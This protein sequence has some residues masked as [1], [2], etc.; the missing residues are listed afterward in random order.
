MH[1]STLASLRTA[2][3]IGHRGLA[4]AAP[5]NTMAAFVAAQ[6]AGLRWVELDAKL[7][8]SGE[9]I[10]L[11]DNSVDRTS[12]GRGRA[13]AMSYQQLRKLDAGSWFSPRF[14]GERI[15]LLQDVL[16]FCADHGIGIN[17]ELKPNPVDYVATAR[18]VADLLRAGDWSA[19]LPLLISSFSLQ[20]LRAFQRYLPELP[21]GLLLERRWPLPRILAE[22]DALAA[23]SFH[24]DDSLI[25][26][27]QIAAV[28]ASGR[29][30]LIWTVNDPARAKALWQLGVTAVFSDQPLVP[31]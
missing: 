16:Q 29:D 14:A 28:R 7:C 19:R 18:A 12:N 15:P 27:E 21:R 2:R 25:T 13:H 31:A 11:H 20:S 3:V 26:P 8:A 4:A 10:V 6:Q 22:L 23:V 5:E 30:V 24:Y 17:I 9:L 1:N